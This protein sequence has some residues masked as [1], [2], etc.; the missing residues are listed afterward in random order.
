MTPAGRRRARDAAVVAVVAAVYVAGAALVG[1]KG[2]WRYAW[3]DAWWTAVSGAAALACFVTARRVKA[4]HRR[5]AWRWFG[6]GAAAWF[7]GMLIWSGNELGAGWL[8]PFPSIADVFFNMKAPCFVI[9]CY[10]YGEDRPSVALSFKQAGDLAMIGCVLAPV[11]ALA[12]YGP[13]MESRDDAL[14][15][16]T[17]LAYP[18]LHGS[19]LVFGLLVWWQHVWGRWRWV[20][21]L[22]LGAMA[23][24][25]AVDTLYAESLLGRRY[26]AG[27][28]LDPVWVVAFA[29]T[30]WAAREELAIAREVGEDDLADGRPDEVPAA[31]AVV[32]ALAVLAAVAAALAFRDRVHG[33]MIWVGGVAGLGLGLAIGVRL[34]ASQRL[35]RALREQIRADA[36]RARRLETQLVHAQRLQSIGALAGG[37]AH[38]FK[39]LLAIMIAGL[40]L[41]QQR[42]AQGKPAGAALDEVE[43]A[44]WRGA[45]LAGRLL[46]L[47]RR[48]TG[49]ITIVDPVRLVEDVAKLLGKVLPRGIDLVV[50]PATAVPAISVDAAGL[51]HALINLGLNARDAMQGRDGRIAISVTAGEVAGVAGRAVIV[52]VDDDGPGIAADV[53]PR[54]FEP[55]FTTKPPGEGTGLGLAMVE[56]LAGEHR[57]VARASNRPGGGARFELAFPAAPAAEARRAPTAPATGATVLVVDGDEARSLIVGGALE[58]SG[59]RVMVAGSRDDALAAAGL[60]GRDI[61]VVVA[62]AGSGL[63]GA[64]ALAALRATGCAAPVVLVTAAEAPPS[65][66]YAA[67]VPKSPDPDSVI[68]AVHAALRPAA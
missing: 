23:L 43:R 60:P 38:D 40:A 68:S 55:F 49:R 29:I 26:D 9:G 15:V 8:T 7:V 54:V 65:G 37:V 45:D 62:D 56:A 34:A 58:R 2:M 57:G 52:R 47:S 32:P 46:E 33:P 39:N 5:S 11:A 41:V 63:V 22:Q 27:A 24:L 51:E 20:L 59:F 25:A 6:T 53:L 44:M 18:V 50:T 35:E 48:G 14:Y 30:V 28:A 36:E 42:L 67:V 17:A 61:A 1:G 12:L 4:P 31:D 13:V 21:G 10:R 66:E 3:A 16:L 64:D 19:A